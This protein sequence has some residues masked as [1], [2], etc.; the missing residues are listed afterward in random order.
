MGFVAG[1]S[2]HNWEQGIPCRNPHCKSYGKPHPN[3]Q[4]SASGPQTGKSGG[5]GPSGPSKSITAN[6][7]AGGEIHHCSTMM[8]H[9]ESC[10]NFASGGEVEDNQEFHNN[11][12][13]ASDYATAHHGL[14][15]SLT[16]TG[17]HKS[18]NAEHF[19]DSVKHGRKSVEN[20][21]SNHFE[22]N[23]ENIET[24]K[25]EIEA[26]KEH[27]KSIRENPA[28][29]LNVG[30]NLDLP[31]HQG[32]LASTA[33]TASDYLDTLRPQ[34][35]QAGPLNDPQPADPLQTQQY[36]RQLGISENPL[37]ILGHIRAGTVQPGDMATLS[38]IYPHLAK[39]I[40]DKV[41]ASMIEAKN[42]E[43][44][45]SGRHKMG[46]GHLFGDPVDY[47]HS[48]AAMQAI[49]QAQ[50]GQPQP[51]QPMKTGKRGPTAETQ[52]T[53]KE[54]DALYQTPLEALQTNKRS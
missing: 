31:D 15:H 35:H 9:L 46:L 4:C 34:T 41:G 23:H 48:P 26:L 14:L 6:Y 51:E 24:H 18:D 20:H 43:T 5:S 27:L 19:M 47:I 11:P 29:L 25:K 28:S 21:T 44:P 42:K 39:S 37:S 8:P 12:S 1:R 50:S 52:K 49:I 53:I 17:H 3:C 33:A 7:A 40:Q 22:K 54:T 30:G 36:D 45:I 16:K 10:E 38:T 2:Q 13:L 32:A